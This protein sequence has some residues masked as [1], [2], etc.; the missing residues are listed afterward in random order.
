M[1]LSFFQR[2]IS[3]CKIESFYTT[4][5]Q[6]RI[7]C[8]KVDGICAHFKTVFEALGCFYHYCP[9]QEAQSFLTEEGIER[10]NKKT[11]MDQMRKQYIKEKGYNVFEKGD[12]KWW[13]LYKTTT[14][15]KEHLK[16]SFPDKRPLR[17]KRLLEQIRSGKLFGNV[18]CDIEVPEGLQKNINKFP[19]IF[20]NTNVGRHDTGLLMKDYVE[21]Q[22]LPCQPRKMLISSYFLKKQNSH[23]SC[24]PIL[25][26]LV[27]SLQKNL[28]LRGIYSSE[29]FQRFVQSVVNAHRER[30]ENPNSSVVAETM[31]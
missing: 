15:V 26:T 11:K 22:G 3:D 1:V 16:E 10:G 17:E 19:P 4:G 21:K 31:K 29:M 7:D 23:Y 20:R 18:Q 27:T 2:Q 5:T 12:C 6:K 28:S 14:C 30:D 13:N 25:F 24:G 9:C 8:F